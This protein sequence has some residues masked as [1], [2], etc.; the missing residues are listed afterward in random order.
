MLYSVPVS[1]ALLF[2]HTGQC[3]V[4]LSCPYT[5]LR[6]EGIITWTKEVTSLTNSSE[7]YVPILM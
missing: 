3:P 2:I 6:N 4:I 5:L 7:Q 1:S